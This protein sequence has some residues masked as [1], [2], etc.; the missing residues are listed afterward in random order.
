MAAAKP[1]HIAGSA[2]VGSVYEVFGNVTSGDKA[3]LITMNEE[4]D[5]PLLVLSQWKSSK[6]GMIVCLMEPHI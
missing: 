1:R 3:C 4:S 5:P 6:R 2:P